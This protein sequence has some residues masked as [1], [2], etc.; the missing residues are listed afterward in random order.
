MTKGIDVDAWWDPGTGRVLSDAELRPDP[1]LLAEGWQRR[2]TADAPRAAEA[3]ELYAQL[4][5]EVRAE[6][7]RHEEQAGECADCSRVMALQFK[8]I[9]T[10]K[11]KVVLGHR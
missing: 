6:T 1:A 11:R 4:G 10:R 7:V 3:M 8:T 9:Y 5:Y 2:F